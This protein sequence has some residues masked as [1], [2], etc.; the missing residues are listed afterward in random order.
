MKKKKK[1]EGVERDLPALKKDKRGVRT[2]NGKNVKK[3]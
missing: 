1:N 2:V 3:V